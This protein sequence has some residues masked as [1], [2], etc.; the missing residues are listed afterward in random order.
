M[1]QFSRAAAGA[2]LAGLF[3]V[4]AYRAVTQSITYDEAL[5]WEL[6]IAKPW[7][8]I[9]NHFDANHHFLSTVL[10]RLSTSLFGVSEWSMRL[11]ALMSAGL[12]F[13]AV[14]RLS[15]AAFGYGLAGLLTTALLTLHPLVL[16]FMVAARGYGMG[17]ALWMWAFAAL[18][19]ALQAAE[20]AP[21][22]LAIAGATLALSVTA[23]LIYAPPAAA[24][25]GLSLYQLRRRSPAALP[26]KRA[27]AKPA[28][29]PAWLW[30]CAPA[31]CVAILFFIAAPL[32]SAK[33][34][35]FY[36]GAPSITA[37]LRNLATVTLLHSGPLHNA[38]ASWVQVWRDTVAFG[39]APAIVL[40]G[41]A[42]AFL[43]RDLLL[44]LAAG[45]VAISGVALLL[46]HFA[47]RRP[48]PEDRTGLYFLPLVLL[49]LTAV[50][51]HAPRPGALAAY[52]LGTLFALHFA[53]EFNVRKFWVWAY[54][55]DTRAMGEY[56]AA[57]Q[58]QSAAPVVRVGGSW[59]LQESLMFYA[60]LRQW[61]W[62]ELNTAAPA[63]GMD[64]YA[65]I[66]SARVVETTLGLKEVYRG[67]VSGSVLAVPQAPATAAPARIRSI[68]S[69]TRGSP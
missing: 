34:D 8:E 58:A 4:C 53:A 32:D 12:Y 66:S 48:Y 13:A 49:I 33:L 59:Q 60:Q 21:R 35:Q 30:F 28:G 20:P 64:Y 27:R 68:P 51:R 46:I 22:Q 55:A 69:A 5:T 9:F 37:S 54:D 57:R 15:R 44:T 24:L 3:V 61:A 6:Y 39:I 29:S 65:L 31:A 23:N 18:Y 16:D 63:P 40:A 26:K 11:P 50:A 38:D 45:T 56:I 2:L 36:T 47:L 41:L 19:E 42:L 43:R 7:A 62:I 14:L 10:V 1:A 52:T 17:L 67:P 25:A